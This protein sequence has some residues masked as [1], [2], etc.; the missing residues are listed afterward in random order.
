MKK[1]IIKISLALVLALG[2]ASCKKDIN[3]VNEYNPN[4][5]SDA[6]PTLMIT[7]AQLANVM[8]SEGE[9]ARLAGIFSGYFKG[10]D[11]QYFAY[12]DYSMSAGDFVSPWSTTYVD[13]LAQCRIIRNKA[14]AGGNE[15]LLAVAS[16]TEAQLLL[17]ASGLWGD[18]PNMEACKDGITNPKFDKMSDVHQYCINLLD[19]SIGHASVGAYS[20]AYS[21]SFDWDEVANTLKA[22]A[23]LRMKDYPKAMAAAKN[24]ISAGNDMFAN[25][26]TESPGAW[27]VYYD[28][29][30]WNRGGYMSC[31][32]SHIVPLLDTAKATVANSKNNTKT[33]E[34]GRF[35]FYF[36]NGGNAYTAMD[37]NF[38]DGI[39]A[40]TSNFNLVSYTENESILA[41]CYQRTGDNAS[42]LTH[43]NKIRAEL[44]TAFGG[45]KAYI[46]ADFGPGAMV[47]GATAGDALLKEIMV[48]KYACLFGQVE[49]YA[50]IRR[51][52]N[53]IGIV[54][55]KGMK[56][57]G[58]FL[59]PQSEINSNSNTPKADLFDDLELFK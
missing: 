40:T 20:T 51:T 47:K 16:I 26:S 15:E 27:N 6:D 44:E 54:P 9:A 19:S 38:V 23:Y 17:T 57:P 7:G 30:D 12:S 11:R 21:G 13:G 25:H 14:A 42:A 55:Y 36:Y 29:L 4:Q 58:R 32:G 43:L 37:P 8:L 52:K 45:Y 53:L 10:S 39:F 49:T 46:L 18:I 59:Y 50:D 24:G 41:E 31:D 22:R 34:T 3:K 48:E 56:I 35:A 33:K 2:I 5:F 28:F 1:S